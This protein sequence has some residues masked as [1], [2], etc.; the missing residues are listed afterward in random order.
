MRFFINLKIL[1]FCLL[2]CVAHLS[3]AS[4]VATSSASCSRP[5]K[6]AVDVQTKGAQSG[7]RKN[8]VGMLEVFFSEFEKKTQCKIIWEVVPRARGLQ[9]FQSG[10]VDLMYAVQ[11]DERDQYGDFVPLVEFYPSLIVLKSQLKSN[12]ASEILEQNSLYFNFVRGFDYGT[13]YHQM[14]DKLKQVNQVEEVADV[15]TIARKMRAGRVHATVMA[16][17]LFAQAA[18]EE[19]IEDQIE[20]FI[21]S[22]FS[23][24]KAG[25]YISKKSLHD[26]DKKSLQEAIIKL[27]STFKMQ[28][29]FQDNYP[30]WAIK[31][32]QTKESR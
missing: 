30:A 2:L 3:E 21:L 32:I 23:K 27:S 28:K 9:Y 12:V 26:K 6:I 14:I 11:T 31:G 16:A 19:Q 25:M 24:L 1:F 18:A 20:A 15:D 4:S 17:T 8:Y 13:E 5:I 7:A 29:Y 10:R 22:N